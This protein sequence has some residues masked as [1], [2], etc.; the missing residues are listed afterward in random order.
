MERLSYTYTPEHVM[1][2]FCAFGYTITIHLQNDDE[3]VKAWIKGIEVIFTWEVVSL[4]KMQHTETHP[5]PLV[6]C[7]LDT[8]LLHL[9]RMMIPSE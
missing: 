2:L 4:E 8:L 7:A 5:V 9:P 6:W 1:I 3:S